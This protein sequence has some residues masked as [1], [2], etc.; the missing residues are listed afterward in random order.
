MTVTATGTGVASQWRKGGVP[1][2]NGG[3]ISGQGTASPDLDQ[4]DNSQ[5]REL[6]CDS[7]WNGFRL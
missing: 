6:R 4:P 5:Y 1:V 3:A 2:S 7:K